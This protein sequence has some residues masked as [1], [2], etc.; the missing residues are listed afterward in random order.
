MVHIK[1][2]LNKEHSGSISEPKFYSQG[3]LATAGWQGSMA[4]PL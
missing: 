4:E 1:K 2:T 3:V